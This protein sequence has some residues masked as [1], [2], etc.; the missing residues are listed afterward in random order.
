MVANPDDY[1]NRPRLRVELAWEERHG[2]QLWLTV[3]V[4][5]GAAIPS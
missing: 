3:V 1:H 4:I 2:I 5:L